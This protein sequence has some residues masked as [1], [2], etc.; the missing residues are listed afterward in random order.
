MLALRLALLLPP[1][2]GIVAFPILVAGTSQAEGTGLAD[3]DRAFFMIALPLL[4]FAMFVIVTS[5]YVSWL[6]GADALPIFLRGSCR[7]VGLIRDTRTSFEIARQ[8]GTSGR[9]RLAVGRLVEGTVLVALM[10]P[11]PLLVGYVFSPGVYAP[12]EAIAVIASLVAQVAWLAYLVRH[13]TKKAV[14]GARG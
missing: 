3:Q 4:Y 2:L 6:R 7:E 10:F 5:V 14:S 13:A 11:F 8:L 1:L 12:W 9:F